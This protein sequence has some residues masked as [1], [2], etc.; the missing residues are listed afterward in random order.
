MTGKPISPKI[1]P[2]VFVAACTQFP[3]LEDGRLDTDRSAKFPGFRPMNEL[4]DAPEPTAT[5]EDIQTLTGRAD[6]LHG[7]GAELQG[8]SPDPLAAQRQDRASLRELVDHKNDPPE[9][10][11]Q[12]LSRL[13]QKA[14]ALRAEDLKDRQQPVQAPPAS[15]AAPDTTKPDTAEDA[16]LAKRLEKLR[17]QSN[18]AT[19]QDDS[20]LQDRIDS[21]K[22]KSDA[23][24]STD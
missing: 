12:R 7:R 14:A 17:Q 20:D 23:L 10:F 13:K 1:L 3:E 4:L 18:S 11:D 9:G 22:E 5:A 8:M 6:A 16:A 21:L 15:S 24:Q 19:P 2:F